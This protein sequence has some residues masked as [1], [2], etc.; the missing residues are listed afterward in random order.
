YVPRSDDPYERAIREQAETALE[1]ADVILFVV[2]VTT[3]ITEIDQEI[4]NVLRPTE[5]PVMV[6]ANKA[7]NEEREWAASEFYRFGLGEVYPVSSTTKRGFDAMLQALV[8]QVPGTGTEDTDDRVRI[9]LVGKPNV[10]KSSLVNATLGFDRAIVTET[11]GTT[12]DTVQSVVRYEDRELMLVD[13]AGMRK[14]SSTEGVEFYATVRSERAIKA[15]DVC[16]LVLDATEELHKQDLNVLNQVNDHK[17]GMVVAVNKWDLA[18]EDDVKEQYTEYLQ[19]Y[20]GPLDHVPVVF[21]SAV[22]KQRVYELL[23]T[24][25]K[26]AER[27]ETRVQTSELNDVVQAAIDEK[28]P[29]TT[30]SGAFVNINYVTQVRTAP[31]VF[32]F[33][34]NHPEG[35][36][37]DYKRYLERKLRE[38]FGF[39]GVPLTLVFKEK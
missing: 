23:D 25:L 18:P 10:G 33:F 3:G 15:G 12:R 6:V 14:R 32:V 38:A 4:A 8:D 22:T 29:P 39:K 17:K 19:Q 24:A 11:P 2:D 28:H 13:T 30:S 34:A 37:T 31:P 26:V 16:A 7:D 5:T 27:R 1:D 36:R 21:V 20:L 35:I 9:S